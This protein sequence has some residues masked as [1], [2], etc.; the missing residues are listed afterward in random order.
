MNYAKEAAIARTA[1][2]AVG[3]FLLR[4]RSAIL[5]TH[6]K[7]GRKS[8][9]Y[10]TAQD[11]TAEK[12]TLSI[13]N[14]AFP[15]DPILSEETLAE[16][17][18]L[19]GRLWVVDP[20]DG[21]AN[22]FNGLS[23]FAVSVSF[24]DRGIVQAAAVFLPAT[25]ELY[26]AERGKGLHCNGKKVALARPSDKL[27]RSI[28]QLGFPHDRK[29][30]IVDKA[31]ALYEDV[32]LSSADVRRSG[33]AVFDTCLVASGIA[34]A[35]I[36]PDIKPW[37][38]AAGVLFVE[39]QGGVVTDM[40]GDSLDLLEKTKGAFHLKAVFAKNTAIHRTLIRITRKHPQP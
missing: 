33:S 30:S 39:E 18:A 32:L 34:G 13:I 5:I 24:V 8:F 9:D 36:T 15:T 16:T 29:R 28:V 19:R 37:D 6:R 7:A 40:R 25:D 26:S 12:M 2:K 27:E 38:I 1:A 10:T 20:I 14:K 17:N 22:Y 31:F 4:S 3:R 21:T 23:Q 11:L 35:Y